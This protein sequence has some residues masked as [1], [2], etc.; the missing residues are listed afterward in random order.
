VYIILEYVETDLDRIIK[1]RLT[2]NF[3]D[4]N[5]KIML[6]NIL[7]GVNFIH[8]AGIVHR[9]IKPGNILIN[10]DCRVT[11]CDF[12]LARTIAQQKANIPYTMEARQ[13][14]FESSPRCMQD[15]PRKLSP[16]I[17]ARWYRSPEI[18]LK[19]EEYD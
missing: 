6:Y 8:S 13:S 1:Q 15:R 12:G 19:Y 3:E 11:M 5:I 17:Q 16:H 2:D 7:C 4:F 9:D 14:K 18:I 10:K